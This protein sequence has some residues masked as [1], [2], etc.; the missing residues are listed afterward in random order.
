MSFALVSMVVAQQLF[1]QL[2]HGRPLIVARDGQHRVPGPVHPL[3]VARQPLPAAA[4]HALLGAQD[5][6]GH[7]L[8]AVVGQH[9]QLVHQ[10]LR[11]VL[12]HGDLLDH[13]ALLLLHLR[14]VEGRMHRQIGDHIHRQGQVLVHH[15]GVK[16]GAFLGGKGVQLAAHRV[17][18][19][20]D[21]PG[22]ALLGALEHHVLQKVAHARLLR[23]LKLTARAQ[24]QPHRH[25][26]EVGNP[27]PDDPQPVGQGDL[28]KCHVV[29]SFFQCSQWIWRL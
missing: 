15:L 14:R 10:V 11:G 13:H 26:P 2:Q 5:R 21:L 6:A 1:R 28:I 25:R 20:G 18:L 9:Q 3:P 8:V 7:G 12:G 23:R 27:L 16:A 4:G 17:H 24:P 29:C 22:R 19:L